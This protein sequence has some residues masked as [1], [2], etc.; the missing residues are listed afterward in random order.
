MSSHHIK[1]HIST[2][3][4][5]AG[6]P[7]TISDSDDGEAILVSDSDEKKAVTAFEEW[8]KNGCYTV[9]VNDFDKAYDIVDSAEIYTNIEWPKG[10]P[11]K[12]K[13]V[14]KSKYQQILDKYPGKWSVPPN[15]DK[16]FPFD[17]I[18][19]RIEECR[20]AF[21]NHFIGHK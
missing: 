13:D 7:I 16:Q 2:A 15:F 20:H 9:D 14:A 8:K 18:T 5:Q 12:T 21:K 1:W 10:T 6:D 4:G 17:L 11:Q 3:S 19:I